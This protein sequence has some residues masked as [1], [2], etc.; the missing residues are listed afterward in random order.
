MDYSVLS[1]IIMTIGFPI[2]ACCACG[3][4]I[5]YTTKAHAE[6]IQRLHELHN[7]EIKQ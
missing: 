6:E 5:V 2:V 7:S 1:Q 3:W 4:F